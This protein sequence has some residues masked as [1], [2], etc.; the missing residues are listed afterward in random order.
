M[1]GFYYVTIAPSLTAFFEDPGPW[2]VGLPEILTVPHMIFW[3]RV[4]LTAS[5]QYKNAQVLDMSILQPKESAKQEN[6][7]FTSSSFPQSAVRFQWN[8]RAKQIHCLFE[9]A[10]T[11]QMENPSRTERFN[12]IPTEC[13]GQTDLLRPQASWLLFLYPSHGRPPHMAVRG[14]F[15]IIGVSFR[16][17]ALGPYQPK[18]PKYPSMAY[19]WLLY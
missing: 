4:T 17:V 1:L 19:L 7:K 2:A 5:I 9:S 3:E 8:I 14:G 12:A 15:L 11:F 6:H 16:W 18:A 10:V 13:P